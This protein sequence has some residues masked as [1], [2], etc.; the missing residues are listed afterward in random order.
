MTPEL[1]EYIR[2]H[3]K[4]ERVEA[5][6]ITVPAVLN[7]DG[8]GF[9]DYQPGDATSYK[10]TFT[11]MPLG[12]PLWGTSGNGTWVMVSW[13][14]HGAYPFQIL[15]K[16]WTFDAGYVAEKLDPNRNYASGLALAALFTS[17]ASWV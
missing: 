10:L 6:A 14:E 4:A 13:M 5:I 15:N 3:I 9:F 12:L 8:F 1:E 2:T 11:K 16:G 7:T 17:I